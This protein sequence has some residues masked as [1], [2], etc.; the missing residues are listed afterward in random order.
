MRS[1]H[2]PTCY[3]I[4][5]KNKIMKI[6]L[7]VSRAMLSITANEQTNENKT[8]KHYVTMLKTFQLNETSVA[9]TTEIELL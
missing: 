6:W 5:E 8:L 9:R 7:Y 4:Y 2:G 3:E 1:T